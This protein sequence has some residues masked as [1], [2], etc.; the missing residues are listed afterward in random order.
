M[1]SSHLILC[2]PLLLLPSIFPSIRVFS[3]ESALHIR[4]P[5][6]CCFS[7]SISPSN[8]HLPR[9]GVYSTILSWSRLCVSRCD[10]L[11]VKNP[12]A[13][14]GDIRDTGLLPGLGRSPGEGKGKSLSGREYPM[15]RRAWQPTVHRVAKSRTRM[16]Q[17]STQPFFLSPYYI[18]GIVMSTGTGS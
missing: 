15:D 8:E 3:N 4:W 14:A 7:F 13:D 18:P 11:V 17:L 10:V 16:K 1:P 5:K 2:R 6:D 9:I 12:L